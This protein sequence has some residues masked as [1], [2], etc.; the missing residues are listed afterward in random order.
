MHAKKSLG[1]HFLRSKEAL[2][3][4]IEAAEIREGEVVLE[5]GPGEGAL[6]E[7]LLFAGAQVVAVE[8][9]RRCT[10]MLEER[11]AESIRVGRLLLIAGDI[12]EEKTQKELFKNKFLGN[13]SYKLVANIPYYLTGMLFRLFLEPRN[14]GRQ[15]SHLVFLVQKEVAEQIV[16]R[17]GKESIFS[18]AVK[19]FGTP[20]YVAKV[21]RKAFTPSPKVDSAIVAVIDI[22]RARLGK[23]S[24]EKYFRVVKAGLG[25]KRKMLLGNLAHGL[26]IPKE[27]LAEIF[28]A[29]GVDERTRGEDVPAEKWVALAQEIKNVE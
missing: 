9:D 18:L 13:S 4:I 17:D 3:Q 20:R 11:F 24:P 25:A 15:P 29:L 28:Q 26:K 12:R 27:K 21:D 14:A 2:G 6:T 22:S 1:Q 23:L 7:A 10:A 5:I 8:A 16:A 19:V